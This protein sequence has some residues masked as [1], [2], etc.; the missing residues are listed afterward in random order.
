MNPLNTITGTLIA[1]FA[2]ALVLGLIVNKVSGRS[3]TTPTS[4]STP[5]PK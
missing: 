2:L 3:S 4:L 1:G 5:S